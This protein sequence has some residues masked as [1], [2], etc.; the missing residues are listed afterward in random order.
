MAVTVRIPT[1]LRKFTDDQAEVQAEGSSVGE[2]LTFVTDKHPGLAERIL[3]VG[4]EVDE[5]S[6]LALVVED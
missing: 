6:H 1:P 4:K 5:T 2:V 3:V